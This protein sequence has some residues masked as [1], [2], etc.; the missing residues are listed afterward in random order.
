MIR[1]SRR[2]KGDYRRAQFYALVRSGYGVEDIEQIMKV[3]Q[4]L[5]RQIIREMREDETL[6]L[7]PPL[8]DH[9]FLEICPDGI[10]RRKTPQHGKEG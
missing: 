10:V 8:I 4:D 1:P 5:G 7:D 6:V 3:P 9:S 2:I